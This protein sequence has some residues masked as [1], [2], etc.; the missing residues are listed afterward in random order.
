MPDPRTLYNQ[1]LVEVPANLFCPS[2]SYTATI[3]KLAAYLAESAGEVAGLA[4]VGAEA[5]GK[6][7]GRA[8]A[9]ASH[10]KLIGLGLWLAVAAACR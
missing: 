3:H 7:I 6:Q 1:I 5:V 8:I 4:A 2:L 9:I 10:K